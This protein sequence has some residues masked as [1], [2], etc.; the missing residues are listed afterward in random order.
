MIVD[1]RRVFSIV[2]VIG[3]VCDILKL[4]KMGVQVVWALNIF[5]TVV[6]VVVVS[7]NYL[8]KIMIFHY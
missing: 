4:P 6:M 8:V 3:I 5:N 7:L 1:A 2:I